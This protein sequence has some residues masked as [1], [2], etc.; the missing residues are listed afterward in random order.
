MYW[1]R[2]VQLLQGNQGQRGGN[3]K[4]RADTVFHTNL[5]EREPNYQIQ[6]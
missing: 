2:D 4:N 1:L 3:I 5:F 6:L